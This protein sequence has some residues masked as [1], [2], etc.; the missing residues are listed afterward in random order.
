MHARHAHDAHTH[1][2]L[3]CGARAHDEVGAGAADVVPAV[4]ARE[5]DLRWFVGAFQFKYHNCNGIP[6]SLTCAEGQ[7]I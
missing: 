5:P 2:R 3:G 6:A 1:T 7:C 4:E